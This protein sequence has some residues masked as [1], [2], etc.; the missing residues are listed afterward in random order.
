MLLRNSRQKR[1][2]SATSKY[3][4]IPLR[5]KD[6]NLIQTFRAEVKNRKNVVNQKKGKENK[7]VKLGENFP[8]EAIQFK[9]A[10]T[11]SRQLMK[12]DF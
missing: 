9:N 12:E 5:D 2:N 8:F 3:K 10:A 6:L 11:N 1:S 4:S 7:K